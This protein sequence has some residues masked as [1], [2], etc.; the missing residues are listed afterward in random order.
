MNY[1]ERESGAVLVDGARTMTNETCL[2]IEYL[3]IIRWLVR[4]REDD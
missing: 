3:G 4:S 2:S 1:L